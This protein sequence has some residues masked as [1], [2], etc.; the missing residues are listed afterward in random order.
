[1]ALSFCEGLFPS[2]LSCP[3]LVSADESVA[4]GRWADGRLPTPP[5]DFA[6]GNIELNNSE[7]HVPVLCQRQAHA[8][9]SGEHP[10][11]WLTGE[12]VDRDGERATN[13]AALGR[14]SSRW[15]TT[16]A[17]KPAAPEWRVGDGGVPEKTTF[18]GSR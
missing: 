13:V 2:A 18:A 6:P 17:A 15:A 10:G 14:G 16:T 12:P 3:E 8:I 7:V 1:M 5:S 4:R 9:P 11:V